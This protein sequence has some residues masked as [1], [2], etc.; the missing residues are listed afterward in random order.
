MNNSA[1]EFPSLSDSVN[2][3]VERSTLGASWAEVAQLNTT[4]AVHNTSESK[5][6]SYADIASKHQELSKQEFPTLQDSVPDS[7]PTSSG[8]ADLLNKETDH[9]KTDTT[10]P[11]NPDRS[12]AAV[13]SNEG[14]PS[15]QPDTSTSSELP[16]LSDLPDVKDML[17]QPSVHVPPPPVSFAKIAAKE[18]PPE[19]KPLSERAQ[20]IIKEQENQPKEEPLSVND[21]NFPTLGQSR[22]MVEQN[23]KDEEKEVYT[24]I[25][26]LNQAGDIVE[27]EEEE[28]D[29]VVVDNKDT[30]KSFADIAG[31]NLDNAPPSAKSH[32][33]LAPVYDES[34][35]LLEEKRREERKENTVEYGN[36]NELIEQEQAQETQKDSELT[37]QDIKEEKREI[38]N[39]SI[40]NKQQENQEDALVVRLQTFDRRG[41]GRI[42]I[43]DTV[44]ALYR[45]GYPILTILPAAFL[46]HL[47]LSPLTSPH[48]FPFIY[49]SLFDLISL[50]IYTKNLGYALTYK[51]PML[52]QPKDKMVQAVREYGSE[53]GLGYWDG[54][55]VIRRTENLRW[56]QLGLWAVHR[57]QW[58]LAYTMLHDPSNHVVTT[59]TLIALNEAAH[60]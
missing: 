40:Q 32:V 44:F 5:E 34:T 51:T 18:I 23:A 35:I 47:R 46:M 25:S 2:N 59:N 21:E 13:T 29:I 38:K 45:L 31:S 55:R 9:P 50:P 10:Q 3:N 54:I 24:E 16:P 49:R 58:T 8:V 48:G 30:K 39:R 28:E 1:E 7:N 27:E 11:P 41:S 15:P 37:K 14:Y 43:F 20:T 53:K 60:H 56:W 57:I 22:L 26:K 4:E 17:E 33:D 6:Q 19:K 36:N 52:R 42:T 12:F